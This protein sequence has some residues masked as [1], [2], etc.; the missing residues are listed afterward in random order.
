MFTWLPV[1]FVIVKRYSLEENKGSGRTLTLDLYDQYLDLQQKEQF[2]Y[3]PPV[4]VISALDT[5]LTELVEEGGVEARHENYKV[6]N[7][8]VYNEL[9]INGFTPYINKSICSPIVSTY[10]IPNYVKDFNFELMRK[11]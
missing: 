4:Q 9:I 10:T 1:R 3:T 11:S 8:V 7:D 6:L 2:R 5:S